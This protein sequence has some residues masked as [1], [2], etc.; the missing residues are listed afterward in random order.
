MIIWLGECLFDLDH[1]S[2]SRISLIPQRQIAFF[3]DD[4]QHGIDIGIIQDQEAFWIMNGIAFFAQHT[5]AESVER[6]DIGCILITSQPVNSFFHFL[7]SLIGKG[8]AHNVS[9]S[10]S[11]LRDQI[12]KAVR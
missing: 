1:I 12:D 4:V 7:C 10:N 8:Y 11:Q 3:I 6:I 5:D 9:R 2:G